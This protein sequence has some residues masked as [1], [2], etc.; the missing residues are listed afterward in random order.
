ML[1]TATD[2]V[3]GDVTFGAIK[4]VKSVIDVRILGSLI[5]LSRRRNRT[6]VAGLT[7]K[8]EEYLLGQSKLQAPISGSAPVAPVQASEAG[9][10]SITVCVSQWVW[11]CEFCKAEWITV[12]L[13][14]VRVTFGP[15]LNSYGHETPSSCRT[16]IV[17]ESPRVSVVFFKTVPK[18]SLNFPL[19]CIETQQL[20]DVPKFVPQTTATEKTAN[21]QKANCYTI[22][23][24]MKTLAVGVKRSKKQP[25]R[26]GYR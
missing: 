7:G 22:S 2:T 25:N 8:L 24:S 23:D 13:C 10:V 20:A 6:E 1:P 4:S 21:P 16:N 15:S 26:A 14:Q 12:N 11:T 18:T 17:Q 19:A 5:R 3:A 9:S